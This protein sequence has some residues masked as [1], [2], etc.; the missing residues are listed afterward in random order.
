MNS[1]NMYADI[2]NIRKGTKVLFATVPADGHFNP[3]TGLAVHLK[4]IG[5]DVR[6]YTSAHYKQKLDDMG[7]PFYGLQKALDLS[8]DP[9]ELFPEREKINGKLAKLRFDLVNVF[10]LRGPEYFEDILNIHEE[11]PFE[12]MVCD[13]TFGG[14]P[15]VKEK[16]NIP[17]FSI[18]IMPLA[19]TSKDLGPYGMGLTPS[20]SF[21]GRMKQALLRFMSRKMIFAQPTKVMNAILKQYGIDPENADVFDLHM[22]KSTV[23]LQSGTPAFEYRRSDLSSNIIFAGPM[24]PYRKSAGKRWSDPKLKMYSKII[25]VTQGTVEK[26]V[27]KLLVPALEAFKD[28]DCLLVVTTGGSQTAQLKE[29]YPQENIIIEDFIPFDD[30]MPYADVY[31]SNGGYGGVMLSIQNN[32]PMVVAGV[33]EGKN[34]INARV[35]YFKLGVN[36]RTEHPSVQQLRRAVDEVLSNPEYAEQVSQLRQEFKTYNPNEICV[37]QLARLLSNR[38][39]ITTTTTDYQAIY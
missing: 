3:L 38:T 4:N 30:I 8:S 22:K 27:N 23:V 15:F 7:I 26:D 24:L 34:E 6:W 9:A 10:I 13:V 28:T 21:F 2:S 25:L 16:M 32:L 35:G 18:G 20:Y 19:E 31:I 37:R 33:H 17:V 5:C 39:K 29:S 12:L 36:L 14:I 1:F 11:F